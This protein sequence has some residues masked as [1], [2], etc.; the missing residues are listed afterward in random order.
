MDQKSTDPYADRRK[1][2]RV[3]VDI[4]VHLED[5]GRPREIH[6]HT[7]DLGGGGARFVSKFEFKPGDMVHIVIPSFMKTYQFTGSVLEC[8]NM[9]YVKNYRTRVRWVDLN[10][11]SNVIRSL[12]DFICRI[13][14]KKTAR[15]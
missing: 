5:V 12:L 2:W 14:E 15:I 13:G 3:K 4:L 8:K 9:D 6:G 7:E 10:P 11:D 1:T